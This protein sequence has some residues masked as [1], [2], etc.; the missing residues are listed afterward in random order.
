MKQSVLAFMVLIIILSIYAV[1]AHLQ[2]KGVFSADTFI[3]KSSLKNE[4]K[5]AVIPTLVRVE[6]NSTKVPKKSQYK[7]APITNQSKKIFLK[8]T[9]AAI[10]KVKQNLDRKYN[11]VLALSQKKMLSEKDKKVLNRLKETYKLKTTQ[12]LLNRFKTHPISIVIAQAALETGWGSSRFYRQANNIFGIWSFN[13]NEPR[14]AAG[15]QREGAK[16]IYVKKYPNLEASIQGYFR[17]MARGRAYKEFRKARMKS[18]NPFELIT[19]LDHYSELRHNYV[20][21]IYYMIKSNKFYKLDT[22]QYQPPG[23]SNIKA[24]KPEYLVKKEVKKPVKEHNATKQSDFN[25]SK[26]IMVDV[27]SSNETNISVTDEN[28]TNRVEKK[29]INLSKEITL[30]V[31]DKNVTLTK[32]RNNSENN[33]TLPVLRK[34]SNLSKESNSTL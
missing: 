15:V 34:E 17:M 9:I 32:E 13:K 16:T 31:K 18:D 6:K 23:W 29:D 26:K 2:S 19:Y 28:L 8:K 30:I 22:P 21:R 33:N 11:I 10:K 14:M 7:A 5:A 3:G 27:N 24:A 12:A 1:F 4:K 20:K 25:S